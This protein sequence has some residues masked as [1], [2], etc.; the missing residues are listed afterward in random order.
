MKLNPKMFSS[1]D[2]P[3]MT[4]QGRLLPTVPNGLSFQLVR[5]PL[6]IIRKKL[7]RTAVQSTVPL[8]FLTRGL[9]FKLMLGCL[10][11]DRT[12]RSQ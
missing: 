3:L 1:A 6:F 11:S 9:E 12:R 10:T 4:E 8:S 5:S 7:T 2:F